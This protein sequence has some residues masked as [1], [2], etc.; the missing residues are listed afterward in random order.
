MDIRAQQAREYH[1]KS[2]ESTAEAA[3][4]REQRDRVVWQL[5]GS[6]PPWSYGQI[7]AAVGC[8]RELIVAIL[9]KPAPPAV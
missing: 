2:Q 8:S 9:K 4:Y 5:R 6:D 7:A 3:R 1:L